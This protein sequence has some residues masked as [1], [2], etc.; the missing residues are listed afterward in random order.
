MYLDL[1]YQLIHYHIIKMN[2]ISN[3]KRIYIFDYLMIEIIIDIPI[4]GTSSIK[5]K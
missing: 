4:R 5:T 2:N 3:L 1:D